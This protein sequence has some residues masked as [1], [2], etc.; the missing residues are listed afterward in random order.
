MYLCQNECAHLKCFRKCSD[1]CIQCRWPCIYQCP[2]LACTRKCSEFCDRPPCFEPCPRVNRKC[3]HPCI[4]FCGEPCPR[5]CRICDK[6]KID[7]ILNR[8]D[9]NA[10]FVKLEDCGHCLESS[11]MDRLMKSHFSKSMAKTDENNN[12]VFD[13]PKCP[14]CLKSIQKSQRYSVYLK[15]RL[16]LVKRLKLKQYGN[17]K[18]NV[19][20]L[21]KLKSQA[22]MELHKAIT[23]VN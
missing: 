11:A 19:V 9:P 7:K 23:D 18:E 6:S 3:G 17:P 5:L 1:I 14:V 20:E 12:V 10:R 21:Q 8:D 22:S 13:L 2:H 4:G 16:L 15:T